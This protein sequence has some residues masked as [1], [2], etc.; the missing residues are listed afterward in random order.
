MQNWDL[1]KTRNTFYIENHAL[2][3]TQINNQSN[4][5]N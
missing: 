3:P 4:V 1:L 5:A 2:Q